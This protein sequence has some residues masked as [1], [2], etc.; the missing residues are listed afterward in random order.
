VNANTWVTFTNQVENHGNT[1]E[2][3]TTASEKKE[4]VL[5]TPRSSLD[6][7]HQLVTPPL[8]FSAKPKDNATTVLLVNQKNALTLVNPELAVNTLKKSLATLLKV[9]S[10][11]SKD[12]TQKTHVA[13]NTNVLAHQFHNVAKSAMLQFANLQK[14]THAKFAKLNSF[15]TVAAKPGNVNVKSSKSL[16]DVSK[17]PKSTKSMTTTGRTH[18]KNAN[19]VNV[20]KNWLTVKSRLSPDAIHE[21]LVK[22]SPKFH[23]LVS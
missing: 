6:Q 11:K 9:K 16:N 13:T 12:H 20:K 3:Y 17:D 7:V 2:S 21:Q 4:S 19:D 15:K 8:K 1:I 23:Q 18:P 22:N 5:F 10:N 14:T